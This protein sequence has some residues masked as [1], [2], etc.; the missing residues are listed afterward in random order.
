MRPKPRKTIKSKR[1]KNINGM[2]KW[3]ENGMRKLMDIGEKCHA[4][5]RVMCSKMCV[6]WTPLESFPITQDKTSNLREHKPH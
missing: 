5:W 3:K 4:T 2:E 6:C 1:E